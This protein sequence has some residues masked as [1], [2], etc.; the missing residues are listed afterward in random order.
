MTRFA[1]QALVAICCPPTALCPAAGDGAKPPVPSKTIRLFNGKDL[2]G[3]YTY[4]RGRGRDSDPLKVFTV[5]DGMLRISGQEWGCVT[6]LEE[7]ADYRLI[8]E[9]KWGKQTHRPRQARARDSGVLV[10]SVGTEHSFGKVWLYSIE[11]Q[12]IEGGTGDFIVVGDN[13]KRF[14]LTCPVAPEKSGRCHVYQPDGK[15]VTIHGGRINWFGRDPDW[16]DVK[17]F[18]GRRDVEKPV[19]QWNRLECIADGATV[20]VIL[21]G[22]TVNRC[23]DV[24]PRKGRI[25][26]QSEGAEIFFRRVDLEPLRR[27]GASREKG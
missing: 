20:T 9:Y 12:L 11:V 7:Y 24:R 18:R 19:G 6:T 25:Q 26:L 27:A 15:P 8:V 14:A 13:S 23:I 21:N 3:F 5:G 2:D 1:L 22:V 16:Q 17:G 10:H 4:L